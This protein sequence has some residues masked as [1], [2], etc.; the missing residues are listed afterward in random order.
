MRKMPLSRLIFLIIFLLIYGAT[1]Q[2]AA[3]KVL[4]QIS[5]LQA[6]MNGVYDGEFSY[7]QLEKHGDFGLG[8]FAAL[9][10]EMVALDGHFYQV[11]TDGRAYVVNPAQKTPFA[12]VTFFKADKTMT[13]HKPLDLKQ[14]EVYLQKIFIAGNFPYA[15][16]VRG[17]FSYVK[18]RSM[19]RQTRP[20]PPLAEV[21][22]H[23]AVFAF[24]NVDGTIVGFYYPK[25]LAGVN[26][27][28]YHLHFLTRDHQSGGHLLAC[29][30]KQAQ[31]ELEGLNEVRLR[32]PDNAAFAHTD[33][34]TDKTREIER[35]EK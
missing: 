26:I 3:P 35:V 21:A 30:V 4:F 7:R 25:Y 32:L 9:D 16:K 27:V 19:P 28:G 29:R 17:Q 5:T 14:L 13:L 1:A 10:G 23:Q 2:A 22:K 33:L 8:T 18:T 12:E 24:H 6:L 11:K 31:V 15:I 20:Y 34:H